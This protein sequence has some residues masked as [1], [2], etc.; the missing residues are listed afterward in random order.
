MRLLRII[1]AGL[2][3]IL[4]VFADGSTYSR[5]GIGDIIYN[6]GGTRMGSS[7]VS[8]ANTS[9]FSINRI[10]PAGMT[11]LRYVRF[12]GGFTYD[13]I[14]TKDQN[15]SAYFSD[16][17]FTGLYIA[18]PLWNEYGLAISAGLAPYSTVGYKVRVP[19]D[20]FGIQ[21]DIDYIGE[22]GLSKSSFAVALRPFTA[23]SVGF[24]YNY[25][26]G[27]L[28]TKWQTQSTAADFYSS[29][30]VRSTEARG[31]SAT[32]G[33]IYTGLGSLLDVKELEPLSIGV[34]ITTPASLSTTRRVVY[35]YSTG[36]DTSAAEKGTLSIPLA[37]GVGLS[38]QIGSR[39][40][41]ASDIYA[42]DWQKM[43]MDGAPFSNI[44]HSVRYA[45]GGEYLPTPEPS[46]SFIDHLSYQAGFAYNK[47]YF[48]IEGEP[49]NEF[50]FSAG[51]SLPIIYDTKLSIACEYLIRGTTKQ[52][53]GSGLSI[54]IQLVKDNIFRLNLELGI[55]ELWFI[56]STDE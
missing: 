29:E 22:G 53:T 11:G 3:P 50:S 18:A 39:I 52:I 36:S 42:Q 34:V 25:I 43:K 27:N 21:Y 14:S 44:R 38:Y 35:G 55:G 54:P 56:Q 19:K 51:M 5:Y 8:I 12:T 9:P 13:V 17:T 7:G 48:M 47:T 46:T 6:S 20:Q 40:V 24:S 26:F 23:L 45:I 16:G 28:R 37:Y 32:A 33:F 2:L 15:Q 10:N 1:I 4:M 41:L 31:S 30:V 49:I